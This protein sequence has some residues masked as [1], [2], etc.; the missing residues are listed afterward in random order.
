MFAY[1]VC[2]TL[3]PLITELNEDARRCQGAAIPFLA[4][5][6]PQE[7]IE[8]WQTGISYQHCPSHAGEYMPPK[9]R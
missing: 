3:P 6:G 9:L 7:P 4:L 1:R 8:N 5:V 2:V